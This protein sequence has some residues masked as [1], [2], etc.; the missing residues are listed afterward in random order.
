MTLSNSKKN[1][2]YWNSDQR[3]EW[4]KEGWGKMRILMV[5]QCT[6][7]EKKRDERFGC[8]DLVQEKMWSQEKANDMSEKTKS[9]I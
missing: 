1:R 7:S 3:I 2:Q 5:Y 4:E 6:S 9:N 8:W